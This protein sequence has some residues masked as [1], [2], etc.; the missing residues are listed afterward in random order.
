MAGGWKGMIF[1]VPSS[2]THSMTADACIWYTSENNAR[3]SCSM[4][5]HL[6]RHKHAAVKLTS[7]RIPYSP[8]SNNLLIT[9]LSSIPKNQSP[10]WR[11]CKFS[12][13]L[14][15]FAVSFQIKHLASRN[16][17]S[18]EKKNLILRSVSKEQP[19]ICLPRKKEPKQYLFYMNRRSCKAVRW[20]T[21]ATQEQNWKNKIV[22]IGPVSVFY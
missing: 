4:N 17:N 18:K 13:L 5:I 7:L 22:L 14:P 15:P 19:F 6:E 3:A 1:K 20:W 8:I 21:R 10:K 16:Y 12:P 11:G 2:P 9:S